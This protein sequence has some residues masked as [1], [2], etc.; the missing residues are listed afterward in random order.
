MLSLPEVLSRLRHRRRA[1]EVPTLSPLLLH[2]GFQISAGNHHVIRRCL[3]FIPA[4]SF[5]DVSHSFIVGVCTH[6]TPREA[7]GQ[8]SGDAFF[9]YHVLPGC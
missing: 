4:P 6:S 8:L 5:S 7:R 2:P 9:L 1:L 3:R